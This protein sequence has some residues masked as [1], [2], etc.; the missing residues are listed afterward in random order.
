MAFGGKNAG[1]IGQ[2]AGPPGPP[3]APGTD[4]ALLTTVLQAI[5]ASAA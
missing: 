4:G 5:R 2:I 1:A 3:G